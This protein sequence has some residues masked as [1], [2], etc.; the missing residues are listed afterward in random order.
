[1]NNPRFY[2]FMIAFT[3]L[4]GAAAS[5]P[6]SFMGIMTAEICSPEFQRFMDKDIRAE[7]IIDVIQDTAAAMGAVV[8][9]G[10]AASV[11]DGRRRKSNSPALG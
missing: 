7:K 8:G 2:T 9:A 5:N 4:W 11:M 6:L 10:Y 1:M 3:A